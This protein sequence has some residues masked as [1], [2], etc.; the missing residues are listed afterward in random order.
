[1]RRA[2]W[3]LWENGHCAPKISDVLDFLE[4]WGKREAYIRQH[5]WS[6]N[7]LTKRGCLEVH[8]DV[9]SL[10]SKG[11]EECQRDFE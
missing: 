10:T 6:L 8:G 2:L 5:R 4:M 7:A 11:L 3:I 1:M 9:I